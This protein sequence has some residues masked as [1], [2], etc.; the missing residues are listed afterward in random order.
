MVQELQVYLFGDQ[1][2]NFAPK[3][4]LLLQS[5]NNPIMTAFF[6]QA[7]YVIRAEVNRV[8]L[9]HRESFPRF[10]SIADLLAK[11]RQG[12]I[13]PA[14]QTALAYVYQL[15]AFIRLVFALRMIDRASIA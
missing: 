13:S 4:H 11:F 8:P 12:N 6:E 9:V 3:L 2:F 15:G 14:F 1:T 10:A 7:Y 5:R